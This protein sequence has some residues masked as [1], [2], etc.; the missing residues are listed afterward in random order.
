MRDDENYEYLAYNPD[1][2]INKNSVL[3]SKTFAETYF[4]EI[5]DTLNLYA[6]SDALL[7]SMLPNSVDVIVSGFYIDK[8]KNNISVQN[9]KFQ[10]TFNLICLRCY[11][12][13]SF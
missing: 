7:H 4:I 11:S 2:Y 12:L 8:F 5:N 1:L 6:I 10:V 3:I 13:F 9:M